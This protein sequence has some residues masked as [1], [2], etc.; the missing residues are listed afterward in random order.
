MTEA[1]PPLPPGDGGQASRAKLVLAVF[2]A[3][4]MVLTGA[5]FYFAVV[6]RQPYLAQGRKIAFREGVIPAARGKILDRDGKPLCWSERHYDLLLR[7]KVK[8]AAERA[9]LERRLAAALAETV[10]LDTAAAE[11]VVKRNLSPAQIEALER[12][13]PDCRAL[14][15]TP[16]AERYTVDYPEVKRLVGLTAPQGD[17]LVGLDGLERQHD[18]R[19]CG[20]NGLYEVMLDKNGAWVEGTWKLKTAVTSGEDVKLDVSLDE[21][22]VK[23]RERK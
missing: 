2:A 7:G 23:E 13:A 9:S 5:L 8:S 21:I 4:A 19:L 6:V 10:R 22:R 1:P 11:T 17:N 3:A 18:S 15:V 12:L 14:K 16:R 20:K